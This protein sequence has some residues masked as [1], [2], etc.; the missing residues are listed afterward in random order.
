MRDCFSDGLKIAGLYELTPELFNDSRG[1]L[2]ESYNEKD[3]FDSG[4]NLRFVQDNQ[5]FSTKGVLRGLHFQKLH[6]QGKLVRC[7]LG[8]IFDVAV[9]LRSGSQTFGQSY[10]TILDSD[11]QNQLYIPCGFAHGFYV[12]SDSA[13]CTYKSSDFYYPGD[14]GGIIWSDSNL[15]VK[16]PDELKPYPPIL[17]EK[18]ER[19]DAFNPSVPYFDMNGKWLQN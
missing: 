18:D 10:A 6:P 2:I 8:R 5:S 3:F 16:W 4:L 1:Y 19:L 14:E 17:S 15:A 11:I 9:D 13:M 7:A 12:L